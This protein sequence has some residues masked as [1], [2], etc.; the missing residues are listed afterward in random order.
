MSDQPANHAEKVDIHADEILRAYRSK[1]VIAAFLFSTVS[2]LISVTIFLMGFVFPHLQS[3]LVSSAVSLFISLFLTVFFTLVVDSARSEAASKAQSLEILS[4]ETAIS[5][6]ISDSTTNVSKEIVLRINQMLEAEATR[7]VDHW[8]ELLPQDFFPPSDKSDNRFMKKLGEA[9]STT[10]LYMFRGSSGRF[11]SHN[12]ANHGRTGL[13]CN[14]LLVDPQDSNALEVSA[15][16]RYAARG[17]KRSIQDFEADIR[18]EIYATIVQLFDMREHFKIEVRFCTDLMFY[19]AEIVEAGAFVS[20]YTGNRNDIYPPTYFY[21]KHKGAFY[22]YSF[23]RDFQQN[24]EHSKGL[25]L[26][27]RM[28]Q[29]DLESFLVSLGAAEKETIHEKVEEWRKR[30]P[31]LV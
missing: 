13:T 21:T 25:F 7:L 9:L 8:P 5:R 30:E 12:L 17:A 26:T 3:L 15:F 24:W 20:F 1:A 6:V 27:S 31:P 23:L 10:N 29:A 18:E 2:F 4:V 16:N 28:K 14:L 19:R 22:Y 11:L